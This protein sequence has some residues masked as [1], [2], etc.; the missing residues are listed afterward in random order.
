M[1]SY[2]QPMEKSEDLVTGCNQLERV[3]RSGVAR[4]Q[5]TGAL[6]WGVE[7]NSF[8]TVAFCTLFN[9]VL[10]CSDV[11]GL[12]LTTWLV[13]LLVARDLFSRCNWRFDLRLP[14]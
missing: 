13:T 11:V 8:V 3:A 7:A 14:W 4:P 9:T 6:A 12:G 10:Y 1:W 2:L 5:A